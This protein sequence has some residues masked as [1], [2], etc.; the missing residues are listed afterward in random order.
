M[1]HK[2]IGFSQGTSK[3]GHVHAVQHFTSSIPKRKQ[4]HAQLACDYSL[5]FHDPT[6][7]REKG[8][9]SGF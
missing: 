4:Y 5:V 7:L 6:N 3:I 1:G 8:I 2:A 9:F